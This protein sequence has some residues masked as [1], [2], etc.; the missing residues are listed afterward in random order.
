[1]DGCPCQTLQQNKDN[2]VRPHSGSKS[3]AAQCWPFP[4]LFFRGALGQLYMQNQSTCGKA[5]AVQLSSLDYRR[6][7]AAVMI[8]SILV[9]PSSSCQELSSGNTSKAGKQSTHLTSTTPC[10]SILC[11]RFAYVDKA[12]VC[13]TRNLSPSCTNKI[14]IT[15]HTLQAMSQA[16]FIGIRLVVLRSLQDFH[17]LSMCKEG[18]KQGLLCSISCC[19]TSFYSV[20]ALRMLSSSCCQSASQSRALARQRQEA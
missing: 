13:V 7:N 4:M 3:Q 14:C 5:R 9:W 15:Q 8:C 12:Q 6:H 18:S 2:K 11:Q 1:M 10:Q 16:E 17:A 20:H 19:R